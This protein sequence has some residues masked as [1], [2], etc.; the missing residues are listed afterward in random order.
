ML[1]H[2]APSYP[3]PLC[4]PQNDAT[5]PT[6]SQGPSNDHNYFRQSQHL[7]DH[8]YYRHLPDQPDRLQPPPGFATNTGRPQRNIK[9]PERYS[10]TTNSTSILPKGLG[11]S[12]NI[13]SECIHQNDFAKQ[14]VYI[15]MLATIIPPFTFCVHNCEYVFIPFKISDLES[16]Y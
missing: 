3:D 15:S 16:K 5:P 6:T 8:D 10:K 9:L 1:H 2:A 14:D 12:T 7:I 4:A 13:L 11:S